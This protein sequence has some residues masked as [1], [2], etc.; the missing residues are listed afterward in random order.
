MAQAMRTRPS[1]LLGVVDSWVA[2]CFD[3]A[4]W[5]FT[6]A[7]E[8]AQSEAENRLP[9]NAKDSAHT[10]ARQRVLDLYLGIEASEQADRFRSPV[11]G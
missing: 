7:I 2:Y 11:R 8:Q 6:N 5:Y 1:T 10:K 9:K 3:R 4:C